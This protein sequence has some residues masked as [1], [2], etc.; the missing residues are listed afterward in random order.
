MITLK[1][2]ASVLVEGA[3]SEEEASAAVMGLGSGP[4][5]VSIRRG[6]PDAAPVYMVKVR[7]EEVYPKGEETEEGPPGAEEEKEEFEE[8]S[9][10][11]AEESEPKPEG[12]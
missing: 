3:T 9:D 11:A 5:L 1:I 12:E 7:D 6:G 8:L 2:E 10:E 4:E